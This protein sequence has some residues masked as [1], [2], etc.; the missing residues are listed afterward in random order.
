MHVAELIVLIGELHAEGSREAVA[1]VVAG[2]GLQ[3]LA[4]MHQ[5]F[6]GIGRFRAGK[7]LLIGLL[8][9]DDRDREDVAAEIRVDVQHHFGAFSRLFCG[10]VDGM[11]F[12]PPEFGRAQERTGRLLPADHGAPLVVKLRQVAV[13]F[14]RVA[15][16]FAEQRFGG[17]AHAEPLRQLLVS[18]HGDPG[19]LGGKAFHVILFL[20]QQ[21][22]GD[23][24][25]QSHVLHAGRLEAGVQL[26]HDVF[27]D[28]VAGGL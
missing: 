9:L 15:E 7:F 22:F 16:Q 5:R 1:E 20:L 10:R 3:C 21:A 12:L 4:V 8:A 14:H 13:G 28:R 24:Q 18:A 26:V 19:H 11:A 17:R 23:E 6:N 2:T 27:P 25:R